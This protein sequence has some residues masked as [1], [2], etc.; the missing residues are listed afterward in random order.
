MQILLNI[1]CLMVSLK[2]Y[3]KNLNISKLKDLPNTTIEKNDRNIR[4]Q[5]YLLTVTKFMSIGSA[6]LGALLINELYVRYN[7]LVFLIYII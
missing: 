7:L 5:L 1:F 6:G 2:T 3:N 4:T